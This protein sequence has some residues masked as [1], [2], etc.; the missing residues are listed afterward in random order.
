VIE[1]LDWARASTDQQM[2]P[3]EEVG[4][5]E[6]HR[7]KDIRAIL[8]RRPSLCHSVIKASCD[9]RDGITPR[10]DPQ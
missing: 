1:A 2:H 4:R 5:L 7:S 9:S 3:V 8:L 10:G 6:S